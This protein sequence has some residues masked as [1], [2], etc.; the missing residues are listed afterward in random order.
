MCIYRYW[1]ISLTW[2]ITW[3]RRG[4]A[5][6]ERSGST[7]RKVKLVKQPRVYDN[8]LV[9]HH[10]KLWGALSQPLSDVVEMLPHRCSVNIYYTSEC[11]HSPVFDEQIL[12]FRKNNVFGK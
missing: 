2:D 6:C 8:G 4:S 12:S 5:M 9:G 3:V 1:D 11:D 7:G 10:W